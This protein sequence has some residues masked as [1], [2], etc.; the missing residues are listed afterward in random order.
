LIAQK[1]KH[2]QRQQLGQH[3]LL[4]CWQ[5]ALPGHRQRALHQ[6]AGKLHE[7]LPLLHDHSGQ[8]ALKQLQHEKFE[9]L[10]SS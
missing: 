8:Q 6:K 2:N 10:T 5:H 7:Q 3:L 4:P 1:P 9:E